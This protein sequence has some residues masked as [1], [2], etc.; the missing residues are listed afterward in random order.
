M[1]LC[2]KKTRGFQLDQLL[3]K[4]ARDTG[5]NVVFAPVVHRFLH[6]FH[7]DEAD[8]TPAVPAKE[9]RTSAKR[10]PR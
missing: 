6:R 1:T 10:S 4:V 9:K 8:E 3:E 5:V 2:F 7:I